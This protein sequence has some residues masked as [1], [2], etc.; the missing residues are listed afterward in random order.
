MSIHYIAPHPGATPIP[1]G[2]AAHPDLHLIPLLSITPHPRDTR[3]R[4]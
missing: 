1:H 2:Q 3:K 4:T